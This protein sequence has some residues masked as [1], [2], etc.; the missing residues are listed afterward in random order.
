MRKLV[1]VCVALLGLALLVG[2]GD[3]DRA[4]SG[5]SQA[6]TGAS[7]PVS[8]PGFREQAP[9][10]G[11]SRGQ[12]TDTVDRKEVVTGSIDITAG[13][14]IAAAAQV[15]DRVREA[16]GRVD[17]RTEQPGTDDTEPSASLT[18]RVPADKTDAFVNGLGAIGTLTRVSTNRDDVTM[19][20]EDLDARIKALQASVDRLRALITGAATTADLIAAEQALASRQGE[21]DSLTAQKRRLDD[22]VAL[23]TLTI[24]ITTTDK[25]SDA[26]PSNFWD[27]IVAGWN[28][29]VDWLKDAVVF[30]GKAIPWLGFLAIVGALVFAVVRLVRRRR[31]PTESP[32]STAVPAA[33]RTGAPDA[34]DGGQGDHQTQQP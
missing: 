13:D 23:S 5:G 20:W 2:C 7:A 4:D 17:S 10:P 19:Q 26:G 12:D 31:R 22:Q 9:T 16:G 6:K 33:T 25:D 29:L 21:L 14:P 15:S 28:S 11:D 27:G 24:E 34:A 30:T 8:P 3:D 18:V 32:S 1:V